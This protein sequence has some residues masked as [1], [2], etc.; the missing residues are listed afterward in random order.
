MNLADQRERGQKADKLLTD[1]LFAQAFADARQ[2][3]FDAW[4]QAP[5]RDKEGAHELKLMLKL[6]GDVR[7]I[8]ERAI[9][10]GKIAAAELVQK[11]RRDQSPAQFRANHLRK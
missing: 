4:E 8:L 5:V 3:I 9:T 2:V 7:A 10:D 11:E 1:P 6:L